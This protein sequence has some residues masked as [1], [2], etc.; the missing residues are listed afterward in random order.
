[1]GRIRLKGRWL[2]FPLKPQDLAL[3]LPITFS[4]GVAVDTIKRLRPNHRNGNSAETFTSVLE[5]GLG[6]TICRDFYFP[7]AE[8]V[9]RQP[10]AQLSATQAHRR[11]SAGSLAKVIKKTLSILPGLRA[12]ETGRFLY[13]RLGFGQIS[14]SLADAA[15]TEGA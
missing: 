15:R 9:W 12:P 4:A 3:H 7:Y 5:K 10:P 11:V 6:K 8:K 14:E 13:P 2:H 1:H